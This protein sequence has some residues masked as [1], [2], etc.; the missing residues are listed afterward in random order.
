MH[1]KTKISTVKV[2]IT[3]KRNIKK[4]TR[5]N[6]N[7]IKSIFQLQIQLNTYID[8]PLSF[9]ILGFGPTE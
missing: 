1:K 5:L 9:A 2:K 4:C 8:V 7:S 6:I 3:F